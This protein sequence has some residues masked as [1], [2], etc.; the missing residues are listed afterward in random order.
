MDER[1]QRRHTPEA[2]PCS[3]GE[4]EWGQQHRSSSRDC[5]VRII[6][7]GQGHRK[8]SA[9]PAAPSLQRPLK[10]GRAGLKGTET[11][12]LSRGNQERKILNW[13]EGAHGGFWQGAL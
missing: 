3:A 5:A 4:K 8:A 9:L 2:D 7:G 10:G 1:I 11:P 12:D 13:R 6:Q